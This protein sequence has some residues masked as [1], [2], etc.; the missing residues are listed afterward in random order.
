MAGRIIVHTSTGEGI[1]NDT[2]WQA[3]D[4]H[5]LAENEEIEGE[6]IIVSNP[7]S[8]KYRILNIYMRK[9]GES[10]HPVYIIDDV[11]IP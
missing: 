2:E 3:Q 10:Y 5:I 11:P 9:L 4:V 1:A 8:G 6:T 7:P